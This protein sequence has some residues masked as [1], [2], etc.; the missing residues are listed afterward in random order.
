M[1]SF[2]KAFEEFAEITVKSQVKYIS[3]MKHDRNMT[4]L[5]CI[6]LVFKNVRINLLLKNGY[7]LL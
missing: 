6:I 1:K 3:V 5:T 4:F 7:N 2:L